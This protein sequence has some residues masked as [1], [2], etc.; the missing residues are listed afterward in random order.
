M[1]HLVL[2]SRRRL[3]RL[4]FVALLLGAAGYELSWHRDWFFY[5]LHQHRTV[6]DVQDFAHQLHATG[7]AVEKLADLR[8]G[9]TTFPLWTLST[10]PRRPA[11]SDTHTDL[12]TVCVI[13]SVHGNEPAGAQALLDLAKEL[14]ANPTQ[15]S[16]HRYAL[17]PLANPWGWARDLRHN[18]DNRDIARQFKDGEAQEM[19]AIKRWIQQEHCTLFVDLHEDRSHPGF[20]LLA[21]ASPK[22][23]AVNDA[24]AHIAKSTGVAHADKPPQGVWH[25]EEKDFEGITLTTAS[26]WARQNGVPYAYIV[27]TF[28]GMPLPQRI[29]I[30]R[31]A[32]AELAKTQQDANMR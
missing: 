10:Q 32:I 8:Y 25:I 14:A 4:V 2:P 26:L 5:H 9:D 23:E 21:Y 28:D 1:T 22:P 3:L 20:Y 30:H 18:A 15:H 29:R 17:L 19:Q 7:L 24:A 27:E 6:R 12:P 31:S 11:P 13:G 16:Q